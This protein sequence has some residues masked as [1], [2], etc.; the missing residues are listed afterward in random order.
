MNYFA[1][2]YWE[3]G[4]RREV[5]QDSLVLLQALTSQGSIVMAAVC[6][7]MGGMDMGETASGYLTEELITWFYDGLLDAVGKKKPL[8]VIRRSVERKVYQIQN[9]LGIYAKKHGLSLGTTMSLLVLWEK[10]YLLWH[11]GDSRAY[12]LYDKKRTKIK[13]LT[14]DHTKGRNE[15]TK[16][17]GSFGF[18]VPDFQMGTVKHGDAFLICSDG[19]WHT[20]NLKEIG[21]ALASSQMKEENMKRR[22]REIG[23]AAMR[24]GEKDNLSAVYVKIK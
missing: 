8:W 15:L 21:E 12:R 17:I 13:L 2:V 14:K 11:L 6:D 4:T 18:F 20:M 5:N 22:L 3:R 19:F 10:R 7:G 16:C 1:D 9:R 24:R 23:E